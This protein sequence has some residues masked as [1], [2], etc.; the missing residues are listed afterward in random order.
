MSPNIFILVTMPPAA[1]QMMMKAI[2][3]LSSVYIFLKWLYSYFEDVGT[4]QS[5]LE[6]LEIQKPNTYQMPPSF[7]HK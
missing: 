2:G 5:T 7:L 6:R 1:A 4:L 3:F